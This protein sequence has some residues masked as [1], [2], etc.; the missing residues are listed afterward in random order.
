MVATTFIIVAH[1]GPLLGGNVTVAVH[2]RSAFGR[3][4]PTKHGAG[5]GRVRTMVAT[6]VDGPTQIHRLVV[7]KRRTP[8]DNVTV[9]VNGS[10]PC[11]NV[12]RKAAATHENSTVLP[13][14]YSTTVARALIVPEQTRPADECAVGLHH[15]GRTNRVLYRQRL[16]RQ[17]GVGGHTE[18]HQWTVND[19]ISIHTDDIELPLGLYFIFV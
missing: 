9:G 18:L 2:G 6:V 12:P 1:D 7:P 8:H 11:G 14:E 19:A 10:T 15:D 3:R 4:V 17:S 5:N 16:E 13:G